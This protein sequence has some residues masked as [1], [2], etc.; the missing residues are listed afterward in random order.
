M[1]K[2]SIYGHRLSLFAHNIWPRECTQKE[3]SNVEYILNSFKILVNLKRRLMRLSRE[4]FE[5]LERWRM[6]ERKRDRDGLEHHH[7][8]NK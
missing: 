3:K 4:C 6:K 1:K 5:T 7:H 8:R 2:L